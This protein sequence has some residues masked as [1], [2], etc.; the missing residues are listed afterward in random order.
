MVVAWSLILA[1]QGLCAAPFVL[2]CEHPGAFKAVA[3]EACDWARVVGEPVDVRQGKG[4]VKLQWQSRPETHAEAALSYSFEPSDFRGRGFAFHF[5]LTEGTWV[6]PI[7]WQTG[8]GVFGF[9]FYDADGRLVEQHRWVTWYHQAERGKWKLYALT[10]GANSDRSYSGGLTRGDGDPARVARIEC[11]AKPGGKAGGEQA[12]FLLDGFEELESLALGTQYR[13]AAALLLQREEDE[14]SNWRLPLVTPLCTAPVVRPA[15][16]D[17]E[18]FELEGGALRLTLPNGSF[19]SRLG[20]M[21]GRVVSFMT[22]GGAAR[23]PVPWTPASSR[24]QRT[25]PCANA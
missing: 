16:D 20:E 11:F 8:H 2:D 13:N 9:R 24:S 12:G 19:Q 25:L 6:D 7:F 23:V 3:S 21:Q 15:G 22:Q 1:T 10:I 18:G 14:Q 17:G 5:K 4:A